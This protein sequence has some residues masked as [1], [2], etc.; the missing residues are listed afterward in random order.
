M[1]AMDTVTA[2]RAGLKL[3]N[4][5][6]V[7]AGA[8]STE[9]YRY[10]ICEGVLSA[11]DAGAIRRDFPQTSSVGFLNSTDLSRDGAYA[12]LLD[13]LESAELAAI[14][15]EK[16]DLD[17]S[18]AGRLITVRRWSRK[19]D[20]RIHTDS[21]RKISTF[22][23]YLN[24]SWD[25]A[26]S[27]AF[28]VR[29]NDH[30]F[31]DYAAEVPPTQGHAVGFKRADHSWHGHKPYEGERLVVQLTYL[32]SAEAAEAKARNAGLQGFLKTFFDRRS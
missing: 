13:D 19:S 22:L 14:L 26:D 29:R 17:L 20:G 4:L 25:A 12:E 10:V 24:E 15:S 3:L 32:Q 30:D 9:P 31:E 8:V 2:P 28:R 16:L 7:K 6:A 21:L 5:D 18:K 11:E 27:G 23:L 1:E